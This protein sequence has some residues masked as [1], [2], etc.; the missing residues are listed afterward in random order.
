MSDFTWGRW[1]LD[2]ARAVLFHSE[3][4]SYEVDLEC[5][6]TCAAALNWI[7]RL[8]EKRWVTPEDLGHL[9]LAM[10]AILGFQGRYCGDG[11][12]MTRETPVGEDEAHELASGIGKRWAMAAAIRLACLGQSAN[13][14]GQ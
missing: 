8:S 10:D 5:M 6:A 3:V 4:P 7:A 2:P 12:D 14:A 9:V 11:H 1:T 13:E